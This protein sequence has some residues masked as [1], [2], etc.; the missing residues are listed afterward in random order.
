MEPKKHTKC[1]MSYDPL[2]RI[3]SNYLN[4]GPRVNHLSELLVAS[5]NLKNQITNLWI[6]FI[7]DRFPGF[8]LAEEIIYFRSIKSYKAYYMTIVCNRWMSIRLDLLNNL[9]VLSSC[10]FAVLGPVLALSL[11]SFKASLS[12]V[13]LKQ[14][15]TKWM[16]DWLASALPTLYHSL[17]F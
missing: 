7:K 16:L 10:I 8:W 3:V 12:L 9:I 2:Y 17:D 4:L 14:G 1:T 15:V 5:T 6:N 11:A 13:E